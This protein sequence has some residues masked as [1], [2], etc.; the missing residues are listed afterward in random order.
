MI[1]WARFTSKAKYAS[2]N[3]K[4]FDCPISSMKIL[5]AAG[6]QCFVSN[7]P[8]YLAEVQLILFY[9]RKEKIKKRKPTSMVEI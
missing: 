8:C 3:S 6:E 9:D 2:S 5:S 7:F 1:D 4:F